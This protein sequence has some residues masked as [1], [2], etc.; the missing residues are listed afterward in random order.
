MK[1]IKLLTALLF[2]LLVNATNQFV[3]AKDKPEV[4]NNALLFEVTGNGL[5]KPSYIFGTIH[6]VCKQDMFSLEKLGGFV[7]KTEQIILEL[8]MD[9]PEMLEEYTKYVN[10]PEGKTLKDY[11]DEKQLAKVNKLTMN[12]LGS[13]ID[14]FMK[15]H[16]F[17]IQS[18]LYV[19]PQTMGCTPPG[20]YEISLVQMGSAKKKPIEG[21]ETIAMQMNLVNKSSI[22]KHA[23]DL[24]KI[25]EDRE[26]F[27]NETRKLFEIY[28]TQDTDKIYDFSILMLKDET[29]YFENMLDERNKDW[30]PK[31]EKA[32]KEKPAF[33]AVGA[34]HLGGKFG[35]L[36][37]LR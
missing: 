2:L 21:L 8:D 37:L 11:L 23:L 33:I 32:I 15:M 19:S 4:A 31:I 9:D 36:N 6:I 10:L 7:D 27:F 16:P 28:K 24:F 25:A 20:S 5:E 13:P 18:N 14:N 22:K 29:S 3:F 34:A 17:I 35:V 12:V 1:N 26:K 30:I